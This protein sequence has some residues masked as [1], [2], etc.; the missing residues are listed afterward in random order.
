M[1]KIITLILIAA[2]SISFATAQSAK[3]NQYQNNARDEKQIGQN[4][5]YYASSFSFKEKEAQIL[6][7]NRAY[8][9]KIAKVKKSRF[10]KSKEK[11][12]QIKLLEKQ[13]KGEI[14]QVQ[15]RYEKA[16]HVVVVNNQHNTKRW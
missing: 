11:T 6:S 16:K 8:D 4:N 3:S 2:G 15:Y 14:A 13:R 12:K 9:Y 10:L 7:I 5:T 1:K